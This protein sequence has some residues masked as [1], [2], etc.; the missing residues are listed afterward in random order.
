MLGK[1]LQAVGTFLI[2]NVPFDLKCPKKRKKTLDICLRESIYG[3]MQYEYHGSRRKQ[4]VGFKCGDV[5]VRDSEG[6]KI[7]VIPIKK[8]VAISARNLKSQK[9]LKKYLKKLRQVKK[10]DTISK[11]GRESKLYGLWRYQVLKRDKFSCV[12]CNSKTLIVAHHL[13]RWIDAPKLR[14]ELSNGV[15]LCNVCHDKGHR[16]NKRPFPLFLTNRLIKYV[17]SI[18]TKKQIKK[19][20]IKKN[21]QVKIKL[22]KKPVSPVIVEQTRPCLVSM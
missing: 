21:Q 5:I 17:E 19:I 9:K 4:I 14:F 1:T 10:Q 2:A 6:I 16:Y 20:A 15:S 11:E 8:A 18:S 3:G 7:K 22:R 12:L 13:Q